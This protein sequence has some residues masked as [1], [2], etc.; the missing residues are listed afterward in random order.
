MAVGQHDHRRIGDSDAEVA[1]FLQD[2]LAVCEILDR[3]QSG[4]LRYRS[5][6]GPIAAV[7]LPS[8]RQAAGDTP[9][10]SLKARLNAASE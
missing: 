8:L 9:T 10:I 4:N 6:G 2:A 7:R 1:V 3:P 5:D